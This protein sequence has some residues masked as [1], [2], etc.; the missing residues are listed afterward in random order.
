M[1]AAPFLTSPIGSGVRPYDTSRAALLRSG[2][3][4]RCPVARVREASAVQRADS[5]HPIRAAE[6]GSRAARSRP[7][8][9]V[10][11]FRPRRT[12]WT[13]SESPGTGRGCA[14]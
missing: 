14:A 4:S 2:A 9:F 8:R 13:S 10:P 1:G 7:R 6:R 5:A 11:A 12:R 3:V